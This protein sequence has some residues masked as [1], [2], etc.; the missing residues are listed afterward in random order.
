MFSVL[1]SNK[2]EKQYKRLDAAIRL[3][4][5]ELFRTLEQKPIPADDYDLLKI[6]EDTYRIRLSS[7][8]VVYRVYWESKQSVWQRWNGA[9]KQPTVREFLQNLLALLENQRNGQSW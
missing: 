8:R 7:F 5:E 2:A 3:R 9:Q 1:L 6:D 4:V